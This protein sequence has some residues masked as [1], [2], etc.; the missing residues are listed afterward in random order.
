MK[1]TKRQL[2][3]II[4]EEK[5]KMLNEDSGVDALRFEDIMLE[6]ED[7]ALEA[8]KIAR[9]APGMTGT[10]AQRYWFGHILSAI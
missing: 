1:I 7:L 2:R 3:R 5:A 4:K 8:L 9:T 6:M 10:R